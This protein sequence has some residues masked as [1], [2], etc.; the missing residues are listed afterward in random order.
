LRVPEELL[1][2]AVKCPACGST[3]TAETDKSRAVFSPA[4]E[5]VRPASLSP[6]AETS[7]EPGKEPWQEEYYHPVPLDR[8][9]RQE[10]LRKVKA[11]ANALFS[12][13]IMGCVAC[14]FFIVIHGFSLWM[15]TR[16]NREFQG[17]V[18]MSNP[19]M[20]QFEEMQYIVVAAGMLVEVVGIG[21]G[22]IVIL[23]SRKMKRLMA[24]R[25]AMTCSILSIMMAF[26]LASPLSS[27][28]LLG[29][30]FGMWAV[31]AGIWSIIVL[32]KP[33]VKEAFS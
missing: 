12:A 27:C 33:E 7:D 32:C 26:P 8:S 10:S 18:Q 23:G 1:G 13:G 3:F 25:F 31:A 29:L 28:C 19:I 30:L 17:Q 15:T 4:E 6:P 24:Y 14:A 5:G 2:R 20:G 16:Q 22:I 21:L 9:L 11:P